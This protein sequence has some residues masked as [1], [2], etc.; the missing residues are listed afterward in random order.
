MNDGQNNNDETKRDDCGGRASGPIHCHFSCVCYCT[1]LRDEELRISSSLEKQNE[2]GTLLKLLAKRGNHA[3]RVYV[4]VTKERGRRLPRETSEAETQKRMKSNSYYLLLV[5]AV[6]G[7]GGGRMY[8]RSWLVDHR[9]ILYARLPPETCARRAELSSVV[10]NVYSYVPPQRTHTQRRIHMLNNNWPCG[11]GGGG[12]G[13]EPRR[14]RKRDPSYVFPV[15]ENTMRQLAE[16]NVFTPAPGPSL[17]LVSPGRA[18][19]DE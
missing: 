5:D 16:G 8:A 12:G 13:G 7:G 1:Y 19:P 10:T 3:S 11:G 17:L 6:G 4:Q 2:P 15:H 14:R 9:V 18:S